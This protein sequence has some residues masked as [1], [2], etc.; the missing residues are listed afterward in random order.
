VEAGWCK[1]DWPSREEAMGPVRGIQAGG[2]ARG[3]RAVGRWWHR[4]H[5]VGQEVTPDG[6][7]GL[8]DMRAVG[9]GGGHACGAKTLKLC[10]PNP[11]ADGRNGNFRRLP[12]WPTKN[13]I[14]FVGSA[15][16]RKIK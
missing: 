3:R 16:G 9:G 6:C 12:T 7:V 15:P 5:V 4:R 11:P 13:K 8:T 14:N 10:H 2:S 1:G